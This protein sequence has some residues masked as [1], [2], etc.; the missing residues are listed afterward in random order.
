[1]SDELG[2]WFEQ[3]E[4]NREV[5]V[6]R[7]SIL[8][9]LFRFHCGHGYLWFKF[10]GYGISF[11]DTV[12]NPYKPFSERYGTYPRIKIGKWMIKPIWGVLG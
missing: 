8:G 4:R 9:E 2:V 3:V 10:F 5:R 12:R 11:K 7:F 1:M 6:I